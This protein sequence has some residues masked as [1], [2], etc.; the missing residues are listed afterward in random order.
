MAKATLLPRGENEDFRA[1]LRALGAC[2]D[3][4]RRVVGWS[5]KELADALRRDEKQVGR[6]MRG[7]ERT[8]VDVVFSVEVLRQPFVTALAKWAG[9]Q[10]ETVIRARLA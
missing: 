9:C 7:D 3:E 1:E 2:L 8:Q 5:H 10:V 6:W 4:A